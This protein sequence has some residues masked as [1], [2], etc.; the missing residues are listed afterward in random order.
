MKIFPL[1]L[2]IIPLILIFMRP[3]FSD[4]VKK[5]TTEE[6]IL[7]VTE[8]LLNNEQITIG[9]STIFSNNVLPD[10]YTD[11]SFTPAWL[12]EKNCR[13]FL[14]ILENSREDGLLPADYHVDDI[15]NYLEMP[16]D[17]VGSTETAYL[18]I[19]LTDAA[20]LYAHHMLLGKVD[21]LYIDSRW[22]YD[23]YKMEFN[24]VTILT[25]TLEAGKI[26]VIN[27][28]LTPELPIYHK[29]KMMLAKYRE[30]KQKG[31]WPQMGSGKTLEQALKSDRVP[32]LRKRLYATGD[33]IDSTSVTPQLFDSS[34]TV[35]VKKF[36]S[37]QGI[38][39]DGRVGRGTLAALNRTVE[40]RIDQIRV[41]MERV[42]W[43]EH[44]KGDE[45]I[46]VNIPSFQLHYF[47]NDSVIFETR[48]MVGKISNET[49]V[50]KE[51]LKYLDINP[52]WTV[53]RSIA[54]KEMLPKLKANSNY[55]SKRDMVLL[56]RRGQEVS[57]ENMDWSKYSSNNFPFT[58]RQNPGPRNALGRVKFMFPNKYAIYLHDT[59]SHYLFSQSSRAFSHGCIR[60]QNPLDLAE[61]L[62]RDA[63][64]W[65]R[66]KIDEQVRSKE[67]KT[68]LVKR[69]V[70]IYLMYL[71]AGFEKY[72]DMQFRE[73]IY[74]RDKRLLKRLDAPFK[75]DARTVY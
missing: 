35:A 10:F 28:W 16:L 36:Q 5:P 33:I 9:S 46:L 70:W 66:K 8:Q 38:D 30:I 19:L 12:S 62:L 18:D 29:M 53:P 52:Y 14:T 15:R 20:I 60:T 3:G 37:R 32:L 7:Y 61:V 4:S 57:Q 63:P 43:I 67:H 50:F 44:E 39:V 59:P 56:N 22:N 27:N 26:S 2:L 65:D 73:D 64:G 21:P 31:G 45:F 75:V 71:T 72:G 13:E 42:R 58:I 25:N 55:L 54:V 41:N 24:P 23:Q 1:K 40:D 34:L 17:Q 49:P 6:I 11:R 47:V 51:P 74:G 48:V 69:E 68:V